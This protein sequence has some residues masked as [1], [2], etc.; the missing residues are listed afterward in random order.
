MCSNAVINATP[1]RHDKAFEAPFFTEYLAQQPRILRTG[2]AV[3]LVI[4]GHQGL[5]A[6]IDAGF[7]AWQ[8]QLTQ[9]T[10]SN[11]LIHAHAFCL[12]IVCG[13]MLDIRNDT[14]VLHAPHEAGSQRL[15]DA[16]ILGIAFKQAAAARVTV[17]IDIRCTEKNV[18]MAGGCFAAKRFS[19]AVDHVGIHCS[20]EEH[21]RR[22]A[23]EAAVC[24][25]S[26]I[27]NLCDPCS[28]F[29]FFLRRFCT[30]LTD[31]T[32]GHPKRQASHGTCDALRVNGTILLFY[33]AIAGF[34]LHLHGVEACSAIKKQ[35]IRD[36]T[37]RAAAGQ[38]GRSA[39]Q[40]RQLFIQRH[41]L[42]KFGDRSA[43][44]Q[45]FHV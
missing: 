30:V 33:D 9:R 8:I 41:V 22:I 14:G 17:Q 44:G 6:C 31:S 45:F 2:I 12:L 18:N 11:V 4:R 10:L 26:L 38:E 35:R 34:D 16:G 32:G 37:F 28:C 25:T 42:Q 13:K 7:E 19:A 15:N 1:V 24:G 39:C 20:A 21:A 36:I 5:A 3:D 27:K 40:K 43:V 23:A 29:L